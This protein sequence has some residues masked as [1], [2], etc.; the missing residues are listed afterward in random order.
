[1]NRTTVRNLGLLVG[2]SAMVFAVALGTKQIVT[3]RTSPAVA[4]MPAVPGTA[5]LT[6]ACRTPRLLQI[7]ADYADA[8]NHSPMCF[9]RS[10]TGGARAWVTYTTT[11]QS[12]TTNLVAT[13]VREVM[14]SDDL[15]DLV[16]RTRI[17]K[18]TARELEDALREKATYVV[19]ATETQ[20]AIGNNKTIFSSP[21]VTIR[22][23]PDGKYVF[24][25]T[26]RFEAITE[27]EL[28]A[29]ARW[30][31]RIAGTK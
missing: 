11:D 14:Q 16:R 18:Q 31:D 12:I 10:E 19:A 30:I 28:R 2:L 25:T 13:Q 27:K 17:A 8:V 26:E 21:R 22:L 3:R 5:S 29:F 24:T 9:D 7:S 6:A 4:T 20:I 23:E 1:M 15:A